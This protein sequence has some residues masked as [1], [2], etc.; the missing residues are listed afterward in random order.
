MSIVDPLNISVMTPTI[1]SGWSLEIEFARS[2][3]MN[4]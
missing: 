2:I 4:Q 1:D 3:H